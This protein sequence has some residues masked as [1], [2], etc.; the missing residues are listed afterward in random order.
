MTRYVQYI[1]GLIEPGKRKAEQ[2]ESRREKLPFDVEDIGADGRGHWRSEGVCGAAA[3][4]RKGRE[5]G[6]G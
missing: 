3:K 5:K 4:R 2:G 6:E 1:Q